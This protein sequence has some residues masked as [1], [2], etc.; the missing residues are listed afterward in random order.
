MVFFLRFISDG[1]RFGADHK[2][3]S[4]ICPRFLLGESITHSFSSVNRAIF[5]FAPFP[6]KKGRFPPKTG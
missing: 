2:E 5:L 1:I 3:I 4:F 6:A